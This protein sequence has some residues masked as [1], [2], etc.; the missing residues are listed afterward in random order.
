MGNGCLVSQVPKSE[1]P[2]APNVRG[3]LRSVGTGATLLPSSI[4][5]LSSSLKCG[6]GF[7]AEIQ[8]ISAVH[9]EESFENCL[10]LTASFAIP[11]ALL[12]AVQV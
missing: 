6:K 10:S 8:N 4:S 11:R 7:V 12:L 9:L 3:E 2:G 5:T 1:G